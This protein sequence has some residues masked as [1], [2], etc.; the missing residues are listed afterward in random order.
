MKQKFHSFSKLISVDSLKKLLNE[1]EIEYKLVGNFNGLIEGTCSL[2]ANY[3]H[4]LKWCKAKSIEFKTSNQVIISDKNIKLE[5]ELL[6]TNLFV[7]VDLP[8]LVYSKLLKKLRDEYF[9]KVDIGLS[10]NEDSKKLF[11]VSDSN[12]FIDKTTCISP[13]AVIYPNVHI[14]K[15]CYIGPNTVI[16]A[17]GFGIIKNPING[18]L[19][20]VLHIGGVYIGDNVTIGS[21]TC[22]D[23]GMIDE[24][25]IDSN[26]AIDNLV[27]IAHNSKIMSG[28]IIVAGSVI[29]GGTF[30]KSNS[31]LAPNSVTLQ[32]VVVGE[33]SILGAGTVLRKSI[34]KETTV[35]GNPMQIIKKK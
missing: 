18:L 20:R 19:E 32:N 24:T 15:N 3:N 10:F 29:S 26:V 2:N 1:L 11:Q 21:N 35:F 4:S 13:G 9:L 23:A 8:K 5:D 28:T 27:H 17:Q 31:W 14:G 22:I 7:L 12:T 6:L 30:V 16:G 25:Y 33:N 34:P